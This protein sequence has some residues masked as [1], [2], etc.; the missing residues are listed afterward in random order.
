M[1][2]LS[3]PHSCAHSGLLSV[4]RELKRSCQSLNKMLPIDVDNR[5]RTDSVFTRP[6]SL[7]VFQE[8]L[9]FYFESRLYEHRIEIL[10]FLVL[11]YQTEFGYNVLLVTRPLAG[12]IIMSME[13]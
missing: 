5:R 2:A 13:L 8:L 1:G 7:A 10:K 4:D 3:G 6:F 11:K 12:F 9:T